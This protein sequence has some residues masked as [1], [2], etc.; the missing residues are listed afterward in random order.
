MKHGRRVRWQESK[1]RAG[2]FAM[3][4]ACVALGTA[5]EAPMRLPVDARE[6]V[7]GR[8]VADVADAGAATGD[9]P[10]DRATVPPDTRPDLPASTIDGAAVAVE[11]TTEQRSEFDRLR[12]I[13]AEAVQ[14]TGPQLLAKR[15]IS[16][17]TL[18]YDPSTAD[19][20][21][22]IQASAVGLNAAELEVLKRNGFV[23]SER[24]RYPHFGYGYQTIYSQDLPVFVSADSILHAV[25][26]TYS[27]VLQTIEIESLKPEL[28]SLLDG[29]RSKLTAANG[30]DTQTRA[31]ADLFL[32][33]AKSLLDDKLAAPVAGGDAALIGKLFD[34][35]K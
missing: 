25:H 24:L 34:G 29:M 17:R 14:S 10:M 1:T 18:G 21:G 19:N 23:I 15:A 6:P 28:T 30:W 35:A 16:W 11:L 27:D 22:L 33:V 20:L 13:Q 32:T 7:D 9:A 5:C 8:G 26:Q 4:G 3:V 12:S 2:W 31:D